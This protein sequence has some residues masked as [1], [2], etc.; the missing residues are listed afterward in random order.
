MDIES[1]SRKYA[2]YCFAKLI[3]VVDDDQYRFVQKK[4]HFEDRDNIV[5]REVSVNVYVETL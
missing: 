4:L 3:V 1:A 2:T 5:D